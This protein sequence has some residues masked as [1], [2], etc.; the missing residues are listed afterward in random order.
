MPTKRVTLD[1]NQ[2]I[3]PTLAV[4]FDGLYQD[5]EV[6]GR[7]YVTDDRWGALA[8]VKWTPTDVFKVTANYITRDL[9]GLPDFGVPYNRRRLRAARRPTSAFRAKPIT[10]FVYRDFQKAKQDI[11]TINAEVQVAPTG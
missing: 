7:N 2:V 4:R 3:S 8:A 6:A 5:A 9:D 1:V 11:G 10:V